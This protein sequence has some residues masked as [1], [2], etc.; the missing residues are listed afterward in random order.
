MII[1]GRQ[2]MKRDVDAND[3]STAGPI[4]RMNSHSVTL[5]RPLFFPSL[6]IILLILIFL[7]L[8]PWLM[9]NSWFAYGML[10]RSAFSSICHQM[11]DRCF[12]LFGYPLPIC[13]RCF[14][15][16]CGS[17]IGWLSLQLFR[18]VPRLPYRIFLCISLSALALDVIDPLFA[19]YPQS[20]LTR[21]LSGSFFGLCFSPYLIIA[22]EELSAYRESCR[23]GETTL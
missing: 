1:W 9:S 20:G 17:I 15:I 7:M 3:E 6:P 2:Q 16:L 23:S 21:F 19:L 10:F 12:S 22:A 14:G 18:V 5:T 4:L 8:P 11:P 13:S